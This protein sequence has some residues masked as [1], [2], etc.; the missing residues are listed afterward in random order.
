M[1]AGYYHKSSTVQKISIGKLKCRI[2][3]A[4]EACIEGIGEC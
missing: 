3:T 4:L 1:K 2:S